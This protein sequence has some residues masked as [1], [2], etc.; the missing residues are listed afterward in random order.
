MLWCTWSQ[1][2]RWDSCWWGLIRGCFSLLILRIDTIFNSICI[3]NQLVCQFNKIKCLRM[4]HWH[5]L[6]L[7]MV[8]HLHQTCV[9]GVCTG[10]LP[11]NVTD[12][13]PFSR[14]WFYV[15]SPHW[16]CSWVLCERFQNRWKPFHNY[17]S[18]WWWRECELLIWQGSFDHSA[19]CC[20]AF[21]IWRPCQCPLPVEEIED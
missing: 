11:P 1:G 15:P 10:G 18:S 4:F 9:F 12:A 13:D 17:Q 16:V 7:A 21:A 5:R 6:E 19:C 14:H 8:C 2:E 20:L 3:V